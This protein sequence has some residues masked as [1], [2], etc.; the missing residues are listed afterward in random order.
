MTDDFNSRISFLPFNVIQSIYDEYRIIE[1]NNVLEGFKTDFFTISFDKEV[2]LEEYTLIYIGGYDIIRGLTLKSG[3]YIKDR[4]LNTFRFAKAIEDEFPEKNSVTIFNTFQNKLRQTYENFGVLCV[5]E[6]IADIKEDLTFVLLNKPKK[7]VDYILQIDPIEF[8]RSFFD[9]KDKIQDKEGISK[10]Y[11]MLEGE[12]GYIKIGQT[13][14]RLEIRRKGVAEP[15]LK[16]KDPQIWIISAWEAPKEVEKR[17]HSE[18][19]LKRKRGEW[20]DLR[21]IDLK[22]INTLMLNYKMIDIKNHES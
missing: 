6:Y 16:A 19:N 7:S 3:R 8:Y 9:R 4:D 1:L 15:T 5:P 2:N 17:L 14:N 12:K 11:L 21:A 10:L 13:K 20:F 22:E 18:Y